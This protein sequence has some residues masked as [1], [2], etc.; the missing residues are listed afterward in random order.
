M[1]T[2]TLAVFS[3]LITSIVTAQMTPPPSAPLVAPLTGYVGRYFD[4]AQT[5]DPPGGYRLYAER[6]KVFPQQDLI[7]MNLG[8]TLLGAYRMSTFAQRV[9]AGSLG[10]GP[11]GE[12]YLTPDVFSVNPPAAGSGW[13]APPAGSREVLTDFDVDDR[14][15]T[16]LALT[17]WG[18]G[19]VDVNG[20]KQSQVIPAAVSPYR[21]LAVRDGATVLA[22]VSDM[23]QTA[24]Y[25]VTNVSAPIFLRKL[26]LGIAA[27]AKL[28]SGAVAVMDAFQNQI[29]IY[30]TA[31]ELSTGNSPAQNF[32]A[33]GTL[34]VYMATDGTAIYNLPTGIVGPTYFWVIAPTGDHYAGSLHET[35]PSLATNTDIG[36]GAG[37]VTVPGFAFNVPGDSRMCVLYRTDTS[38]QYDLG[39][40]F[41]AS[42]ARNVGIGPDS[43]APYVTGGKAYLIAGLAGVGELFTIDA[44]AAALLPPALPA[45]GPMLLLTL[46]LILTAMALQR[47]H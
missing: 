47:L 40:Y 24:V 41:R 15:Y 43:F 6:I 44:P 29:R 22:F 33:P 39:P 37:F 30:A 12:R 32:G 20:V 18:F 5:S 25:D 7:L 23:T 21:I 11:N 46:V 19:I 4:A 8:G 13:I 26:P 17:S 42:Y 10:T 34:P 31:H 45:L 28:N 36:F 27:Y 2:A 9:S 38:A 35:I 1:R 3:S 14:G 16:Y